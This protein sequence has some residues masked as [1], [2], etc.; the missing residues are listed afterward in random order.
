MLGLACWPV[1]ARVCVCLCVWARVSR[2]GACRLLSARAGLSWRVPAR[3]GAC[4]FVLARAGSRRRVPAPCRPRS[5][6]SELAGPSCWF[7]Q[8][9]IGC[10]G[11]C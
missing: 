10:V 8:E 5:F 11:L 3:V 2:V 6:L 4:R 9:L 1:S 7:T